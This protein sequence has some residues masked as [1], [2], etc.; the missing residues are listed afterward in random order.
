MSLRIFFSLLCFALT[1][2]AVAQEATQVVFQSQDGNRSFTVKQGDFLK[3]KLD[4]QSGGSRY[5]GTF[6]KYA[7]GKIFLKN[8]SGIPLDQVARISYRTQAM[9]RLFWTVFL[10]GY[11]LSGAGLIAFIAGVAGPDPSMAGAGFHFGP[12]LM[13]LGFALLLASLIIS[14]SSLHRE[15]RPAAGWVAVPILPT[16]LRIPQ[17]LP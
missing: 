3:I 16:P 1:I 7:G 10:L 14:S 4:E 11:L 8:R 9:R 13:G 2:S 12:V 15:V 17:P 6:D 5:R